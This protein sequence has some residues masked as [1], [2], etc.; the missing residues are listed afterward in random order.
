MTEH[1]QNIKGPIG[2][3]FNN[4]HEVAS[5]ATLYAGNYAVAVQENRFT[6]QQA[7]EIAGFNAQPSVNIKNAKANTL[8]KLQENIPEKF[9]NN[10]SKAIVKY[11]TAILLPERCHYPSY[12]PGGENREGL[13]V[14]SLHFR[15]AAS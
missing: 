1:Q 2:P 7:V 11:L 4:I 10:I 9:C 6:I 14:A 15:G 3:W 12:S 5:A 13:Y 8:E